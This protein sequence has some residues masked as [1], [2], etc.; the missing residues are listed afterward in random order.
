MSNSIGY[1]DDYVLTG[2][3]VDK[4]HKRRGF[5]FVLSSPSG[6]GKTTLSRK[7]LASEKRLKMSI[8]VTTRPMRPGEVDEEDYF[9]TDANGF[10][11]M[12]EKEEFLEHAVVFGQQYGTRNE[13]VN[14]TL[15]KGKDV[16]FDIDWQGTRQLAGKR[17]DDL[18]SVFILPPS[19]KELERRLRARGQDSEEVVQQRMAK[20]EAEIS[21][22]EEYDYVVINNDV[23][24]ALE[25]ITHI[26]KAERL[27]RIRQ[28]YLSE[29]IDALGESH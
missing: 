7:L 19:L 9:F 25:E 14:K 8:S 11:S 12:I 21:H 3:P 5:M 17:R 29:F 6:A 24:K 18:V 1:E 2:T 10:D 23:D 13:Y 26:L 20:A 22:W 4:L 15:A 16:L 27:K 28:T